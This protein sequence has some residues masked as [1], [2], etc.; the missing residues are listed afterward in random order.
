MTRLLAAA[1][2]LALTATAAPALAQSDT[3]PTAAPA[4]PAAVAKGEAALRTVI[5]QLR[6]GKP[7]YDAMSAE[8]KA[9]VEPQVGPIQ[10]VIAGLGEVKSVSFA[11]M[12]PEGAMEYRVEFTGGLTQWMI[13]FDAAGKIDGLFFKPIQ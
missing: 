7:D 8:M 9:G 1:L 11:Q 5:E 13:H 3:A 6:A 4:D 2:A 12:S 10:Q